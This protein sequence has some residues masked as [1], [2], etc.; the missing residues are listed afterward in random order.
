[1]ET[2]KASLP[3]RPATPPVPEEGSIDLWLTPVPAAL[4]TGV[5]H[6]LAAVLSADERERMARFRFEE[7]RVRYLCAHAS[8]RELLS[9]YRPDVAP[10]D[11][12]FSADRFGKP[13]LVGAPVPLDF[14]LSHTDGLVAI[15]V[16]GG[17]A[18]G[19]DVERRRAAHDDELLFEACLAESEAAPLRRL[20]PDERGDRFHV[21][22]TLKEAYLKACGV[23]LSRD[24]RGVE[25]R[26]GPDGVLLEVRDAAGVDARWRFGQATLEDGA[27]ALAVATACPAPRPGRPPSTVAVRIRERALDGAERER[28]PA[29]ALR[30]VRVRRAR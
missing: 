6:A 26:L 11:W 1:M 23:G 10:G 29:L 5:A 3:G 13:G 19:V 14:N 15:A 21:L 27:V 2:A 17:T 18:V 12:R 22:W 28:R 7:D 9:G 4:G 20:R 30:D 25:L 16:T 8:L 24:L